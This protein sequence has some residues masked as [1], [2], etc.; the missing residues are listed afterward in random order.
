MRAEPGFGFQ[1]SWASRMMRTRFDARARASGVTR[2][3]WR[4]IATIAYCEGSTQSE[5]AST[6]EINSVTAGRIID[7]L[8]ASG[9][10]ERR[11]DPVDRRANRLYLL[12]AAT[13]M[14]K[15]FSKI[16]LAEEQLAIEGLTEAEQA[17]LTALLERV[18]ANLV[19]APKPDVVEAMETEGVD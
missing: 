7:R 5:I 8:E 10:I 12:P 1:I 19:R 2:A 16:A 9:W 11:S 14:L 17:T 6:L 3:Q 15:L 18:I 13:P 4:T